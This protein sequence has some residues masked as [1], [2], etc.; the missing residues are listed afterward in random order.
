LN[1]Y[2]C[3]IDLKDD[4]KALA[5]AHAVQAWL[6]YLAD[7]GTLISWRMM[8]QKLNLA[9]GACR[10]FLIEI[11]VEDMAQLDALFRQASTRDDAAERLYTAVHQMVGAA[12]FGLYRPYPDP[13][14]AERVAIF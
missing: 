2:H 5:F 4:A 10:D 14:R 7:Q 8:R 3:S 6:D 13:T 1:L 11:E 12:E 9:S